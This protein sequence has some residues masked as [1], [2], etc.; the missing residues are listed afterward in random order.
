MCY[1]SALTQDPERLLEADDLDVDLE[2]EGT[3]LPG[4]AETVEPATASA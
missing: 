2:E 4:P 3:D 1:K